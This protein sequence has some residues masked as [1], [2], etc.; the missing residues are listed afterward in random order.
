MCGANWE[1]DTMKIAIKAMIA[2]AAVCAFA[3]PASAYTV[4]GTVPSGQVTF[5]V[6]KP[7]TPHQNHLKLT[8]TFPQVKSAGIPYSVGVCVAYANNP[9]PCPLPQDVSGGEQI[10]AIYLATEEYKVTLGQATIAAVPYVLNVVY[11]P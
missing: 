11:V 5:T 3:V 10:I 9:S 7:T 4:N 6:Q 2:G 1:G 8:L